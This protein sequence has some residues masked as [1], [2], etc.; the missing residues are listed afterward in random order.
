[1]PPAGAQIPGLPGLPVPPTNPPPPPSQPPPTTSGP[2]AGPGEVVAYHGNPAGD[3]N[4]A[5]ASGWGP[6]GQ[7]WDKELPGPVDQPLVVGGKV[8]VN[9]SNGPQKPYGSRVI[10]YDAV[11][12][13]EAWRQETP[14]VYF[15]AP[16]A[17]NA[18]RVISINQDGV[19][20][21]FDVAT[22]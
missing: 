18:G 3:G 14:G 5:D 15:T 11:T 6:L 21:A 8:I 17:A 20:R 22:G 4:G 16:I 13:A 10:A 1:A 19:V 2:G 9:T 7:V 12:G